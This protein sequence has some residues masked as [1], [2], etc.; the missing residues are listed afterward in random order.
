MFHKIPYFLMAMVEHTDI[1]CM[2]M[3]P[4]T[5][6]N[7]SL[8]YLERRKKVMVQTFKNQLSSYLYFKFSIIFFPLNCRLS[9]KTKNGCK[10]LVSW[11][12]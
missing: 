11:M 9:T 4:H 8:T 6:Y 10:R 5:K 12:S 1:H 7:V 3:H 2:V